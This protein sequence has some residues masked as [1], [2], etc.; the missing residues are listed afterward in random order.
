MAAQLKTALAESVRTRQ[1]PGI[2]AIV[3]DKTGKTLFDE[4]FGTLDANNDASKAFTNDTQLFLWSCTKLITSICALQLLEQ[5]KIQSLDDPVA[6]Y[7]P[8]VGEFKVLERFDENGK[9]ILRKPKTEMRLIHLMTHT[10]GLTYDF[11]E[12]DRPMYEYR[13]SKG[14]HVGSY[15]SEEN[16]EWQ[17]HDLF[18]AFDPGEK[19]HYGVNMDHLGFIVEAVSGLRLEEYMSQNIFKPLGMDS[20]GPQFKNEEFLR[21]HIKDE[22]GL[23]TIDGFRP[24][25]NPWRYGG[26]HFLIGSLRDY[27]QLM[28]ALLNAGSHP[29]T[30]RQILRPETVENYV[31]KDFI[32]VVGASPDGIGTCTKAI[33]PN[34]SNA[35][36]VGYSFRDSPSPRG[37][38][39]GLMMN[40]EDVV[41]GRSA[42]SGS[43]AG[44]GNLYYWVDPKKGIA[45]II[46]T[47]VLPFLDGQSLRLFE[48]VERLAYT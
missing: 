42:G 44:L 47:N 3:I 25:K 30:G 16:N 1:T 21:V 29:A 5:G 20:C 24:P 43:W 35:G 11:W 28:L 33:T 41:G 14:Q 6:K 31:F 38:S 22:N 2:G 10:S 46:G 23:T 34:S 39:C 32:P 37:W 19:H 9:P 12:A 27:T 48:S 18:L 8:Q 13:T 17:Y 4:S 40:L 36:D 15:T 7:L 45:G 26:G